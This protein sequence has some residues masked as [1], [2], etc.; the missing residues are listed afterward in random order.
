[1]F[2]TNILAFEN[3]LDINRSISEE[4]QIS[5]LTKPTHPPNIHNEEI[6]LGLVKFIPFFESVNL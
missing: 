4:G 5:K 1:M 6:K 2:I 3:N